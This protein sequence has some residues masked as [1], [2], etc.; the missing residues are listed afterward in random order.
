MSV[1]RPIC[2]KKH[3]LAIYGIV[4]LWFC[5]SMNPCF[6]GSM[7]PELQNHELWIHGTTKTWIHGSTEPCIHRTMNSWK[8]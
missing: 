4:N 7:N 3:R 2:D 5:V 8:Y 1:A 6:C